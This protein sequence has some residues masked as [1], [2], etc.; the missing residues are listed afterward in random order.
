[1]N[2]PRGELVATKTAQ[3]AHG[4]VAVAVS[5]HDHDHVHVNVTSLPQPLLV[6]PASP[7]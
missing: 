4:H 2:S 5:V 7:S 3:S 6:P 1:M